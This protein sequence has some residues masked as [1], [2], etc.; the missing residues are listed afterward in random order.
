MRILSF[1]NSFDELAD[2]D[3][4]LGRKVANYSAVAALLEH[5]SFASY[6]SSSPLRNGAEA[7]RGGLR[8]LA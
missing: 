2:A 1:V 7:L 4:H 8:P 6:I 3:R 5:S